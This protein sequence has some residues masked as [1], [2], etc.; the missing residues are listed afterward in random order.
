MWDVEK[1]E[2]AFNDRGVGLQ[3]HIVP[4]GLTRSN[5]IPRFPSGT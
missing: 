4:G 5:P 1:S 3:W 2:E